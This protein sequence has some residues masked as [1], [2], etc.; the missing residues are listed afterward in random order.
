VGLEATE[1]R[2]MEAVISATGHA[3]HASSEQ[4]DNS[5]YRLSAALY[6]LQ[7]HPRPLV[8]NPVSSAFAKAIKTYFGQDLLNDPSPYI[9]AMFHDALVPTLLR[10]GSDAIV[11]PEKACAT[12]ICRL[13]PTTDKPW[14]RDLVFPSNSPSCP[15]LQRRPPPRIPPSLRPM[16][17]PRAAISAT[18]RCC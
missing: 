3:G 10:G 18:F 13:L 17:T 5:I 1:K 9:R 12:L 11:L 6:K 2:I 14:W 8:L 15:M 7:A 4:A 16:P